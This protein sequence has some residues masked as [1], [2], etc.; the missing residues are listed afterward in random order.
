MTRDWDWVAPLGTLAAVII[1]VAL[2]KYPPTG[3]GDWAT[4]AGSTGTVAAIFAAIFVARGDAR[5]RE[6]ERVA[7]IKGIQGVVKGARHLLSRI[8]NGNVFRYAVG[9][10]A[11]GKVFE[12][13]A[14]IVNRSAQEI[15]DVLRDIPLDKLA[16]IDLIDAVLYARQGVQELRENVVYWELDDG[17]PVN[18]S[19]VQFQMVENLI[20]RALQEMGIGSRHI[21]DA[22]KGELSV[23]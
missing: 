5:R 6:R 9:I 4:W 8:E 17:K 3:P 7:L 12:T 20:D 21:D 14:A 11:E 10:C 16:E 13:Y 23:F 18:Q 2:A 1:I 19:L 15:Y 22:A